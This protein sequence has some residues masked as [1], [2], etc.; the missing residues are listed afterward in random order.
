M[1]AFLAAVLKR[2]DALSDIVPRQLRGLFG[3]RI[4]GLKYLW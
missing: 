2:L 1:R 3:I 4:N